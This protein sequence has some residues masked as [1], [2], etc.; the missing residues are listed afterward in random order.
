MVPA[1]LANPLPSS[2]WTPFTDVPLPGGIDVCPVVQERPRDEDRPRPHRFV[3]RRHPIN[4]AGAGVHVHPLRQE[5]LN[6]KSGPA[7][8]G[9]VKCPSP[10]KQGNLIYFLQPSP[11]YQLPRGPI[12]L[13][14]AHLSQSV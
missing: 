11:P 13:V 14:L 7:T 3:K 10:S 1:F 8:R 2:V 12:C 6:Q 5:M 9:F 4:V